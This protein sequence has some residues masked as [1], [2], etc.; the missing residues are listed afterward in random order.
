MQRNS[1]ARRHEPRRREERNATQAPGQQPQPA[2]EDKT[3]LQNDVPSFFRAG[4]FA[5]RDPSLPERRSGAEQRKVS[6]KNV[7]EDKD[8]D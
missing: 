1:A 3:T 7:L 5:V 8:E 4:E 2:D 6:R